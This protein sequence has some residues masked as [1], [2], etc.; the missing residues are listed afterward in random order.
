MTVKIGS[1]SAA[2]KPIRYAALATLALALFG[3]WGYLY[4]KARAVDLLAANEVMAGL[5]ELKEIDGRWNDWLIGTRL[6]TGTDSARPST[7]DPAR[8]ARIHALLAVKIFSLDNP[9]PPSTLVGLKQAFDARAKSVDNFATARTS[10]LR[11][12]AAFV[13]ANDAFANT[14][15]E[16]GTRIPTTV[17]RDA[18]RV[19]ETVLSYVAQ[20]SPE[21]LTAAQNAFAQLLDD[22]L[23][24]A[25]RPQ[26]EEL[27]AAARAVLGEKL[28]ED[29]TFREAFYAATGPRLDSAMRGFEVGF[30]NALDEAERYRMYLLVYSGLVLLLAAWLAWRITGNYRLIGKLNRQLRE[31]N[32][33]LEDRVEK[34]TRE[35]KVAL[36]QLKE[37]EALLI[38]SE[39]MSS[40]GQMVA[41]VAH[42]VNTPLAY[43]KASLDS[44]HSRMPNVDG[45]LAE[46]EKLLRMLE[47]DNADERVLS[48]QFGTVTAALDEIRGRGAFTDLDRLVRD[49]L[50]G[51]G[52]ISE[53][54]SNLKNFARLDRSRVAEFDLNEGLAS[55]LAIA[56]NELKQR[57]VKKLLG[58]IPKVSCAPSQINQVFLNL[59][60]NAAQAT[61]ADSGVI[62]VR[63]YQP[64]PLHVAVEVADNGH[65]IPEEI[66]PKIFDPFF[67]TKEV[68]KGTGLGLSISYKIVESHGGRIDVHSKV[69]V[70]TRFTV[71][72]PVQ[73]APAVAEA[74]TA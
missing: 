35:L 27:A 41:G 63:T 57:T 42:E 47:S 70:G 74:V 43:V 56:R 67:T 23:P 20:A 19:H 15:R 33:F 73:P 39:K 8:L 49:G 65:G 71:T 28:N 52:Q 2:A 37:Q 38:Q 30:G 22:D 11:A 16:R 6:A 40:L 12:F 64:D 59:L 54:V 72:L 25:A 48:T 9:L 36:D 13:R 53:L 68:G 44:V 10:Y 4:L 3:G 69:G 21:A 46:V 29:A 26:R 5:R 7:V 66:L 62:T 60:T 31:A 14:A 1:W 45:A 51:I 55:A 32:E 50:H 34:R 58:A 61:A 18:E 17:A 24:E